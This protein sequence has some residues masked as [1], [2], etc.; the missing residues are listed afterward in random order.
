MILL[1]IYYFDEKSYHIVGT[2]SVF[3][4]I[5]LKKGNPSYIKIDNYYFKLVSHDSDSLFL[6][7]SKDDSLEVLIEE[8]KFILEHWF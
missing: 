8:D 7:D 3:K 4:N 5:I 6:V 1:D 2:Y